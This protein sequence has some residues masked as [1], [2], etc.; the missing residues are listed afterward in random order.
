MIKLL[1]GFLYAYVVLVWILSGL[2][3]LWT[4]YIA[5]TLGGAFWG[6]VAFFCPVISQISLGYDAWTISGFES[7]YIQWLL[8]TVVAW[9][10]QYVFAAI[11]G[12]TEEKLNKTM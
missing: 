12:I 7:P 9:V 10:L 3:H 1:S 11:F 6:F 4:V 8:I 5:Y 2:I